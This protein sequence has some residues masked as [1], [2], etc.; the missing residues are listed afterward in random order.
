MKFNPDKLETTFIE[1]MTPYGP[2]EGR[3]YTLT[4]SDETGMMFLDIAD[5]YNYKVINQDLRD[6]LLGTW[7]IIYDN[8]Y[9]LFLYA[10][11]GDLDYFSALMK[12][13]AFKYHMNLALQ[14]IIYGDKDLIK[15]YPKL[16]NSP[17]YVKFDSLFPIF[18]N[19]EFY[20]Y[21]KD[22]II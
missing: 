22:Y 2:I 18:N 10:Y 1:P 15:E 11:I 21:V 19:Y 3:K 20:G 7:R 6:E 9:G 8:D 14:A 17:I 12:Y 4:H 13:S 16:I 5:E